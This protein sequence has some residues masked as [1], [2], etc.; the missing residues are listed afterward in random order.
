[1]ESL[2]AYLQIMT[3]CYM[4]FAH[5]ANDVANSVGPLSAIVSVIK[6]NEIAVKSEVP[7]FVLLIGGVGIVIGLLTYGYKVIYTIGQKITEL[8]PSRGFSAEFATATVVL[9]FSKLS[10]PISTTHTIVGAVIGVGYARGIAALNL[11]IIKDIIL[12]WA[13]TLPVTIIMS[14]ILYELLLFIF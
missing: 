5:G 2:F 8:T 3:A 6:N 4:A 11:S 13:W 14:I 12:T 9:V 1:M 7:L 10:V